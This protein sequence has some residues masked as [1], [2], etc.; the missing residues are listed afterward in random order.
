MQ[1]LLT[2]SIS[3]DGEVKKA[4]GLVAGHAYSVLDAKRFKEVCTTRSLVSVP[5]GP[6]PSAYTHRHPRGGT[7]S[8]SLS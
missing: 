5:I 6:R 4:S 2:A 8:P 3:S 7:R 1:A